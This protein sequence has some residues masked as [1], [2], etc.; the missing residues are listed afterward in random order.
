[1][2]GLFTLAENC[3]KKSRDF[4]SLFMFYSCYGD[5][6]GLMY[7]LAE[8][9]KEGK[10]NIAYETAF[11]LAMPEKCVE[12]LVKSKRYSEAAMFARSYIPSMI[13]SIM[14]DWTELLKTNGLPFT[15]ENIFESKETS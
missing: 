9:E 6:D 3:F 1:M 14:N 10:L 7:L 15:P 12:I 4:N 5:Q 2:A 13:P 11:L 8:A